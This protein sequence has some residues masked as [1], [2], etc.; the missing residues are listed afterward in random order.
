MLINS[1]SPLNAKSLCLLG[2]NFYSFWSSIIWILNYTLTKNAQIN[3]VL[4]FFCYYF[5]IALFPLFFLLWQLL[6]IHAVR[7]IINI[8][9]IFP[10]CKIF[11]LNIYIYIYICVCMCVS[12]VASETIAHFKRAHLS[13]SSVSLENLYILF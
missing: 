2:Y 9:D 6:S 3:Y 8:Y 7:I 12:L 13:F 11:I 4:L 10:S 5:S 1:I